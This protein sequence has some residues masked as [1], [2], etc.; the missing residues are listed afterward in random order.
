M[1]VFFCFFFFNWN[2]VALQCCIS[3]CCTSEW[4]SYYTYISSLSHQS[5]VEFPVLHSRFSLVI[6][7][8]HSSVCMSIPISQFIPPALFPS[9][10]PIHLRRTI[11]TVVHPGSEDPGW[12]SAQS[13]NW[14]MALKTK[15]SVAQ[16]CLTLCNPMD[17]SLP[18]FSVHEILQAKILEWITIPFS[19]GSSWP[20]NQTWVS[21][22]AGRFFTIWAT[23]EALLL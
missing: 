11:L 21:C 22:T 16:S 7:F 8:I 9:L 5:R 18:G 20:R 23:R 10:V 4:I 15:V 3:F 6:Y 14:Y 1:Y 19:R 2:L 17:F 12:V 13:R